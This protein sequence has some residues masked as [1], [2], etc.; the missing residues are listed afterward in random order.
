MLYL[1][2]TILATVILL[3]LAL[4]RLPYL[5][6][7]RLGMEIMSPRPYIGKSSSPFMDIWQRV[8]SIIGGLSSSVRRPVSLPMPSLTRPNT[9]QASVSPSGVATLPTSRETD[10]T[11]TLPMTAHPGDFWQEDAP[12][13]TGILEIPTKGLITR[14]GESQKIAHELVIRADESFRKKD[15]KEAEKF[16]L[17]AATKD[18]DNARIYSRLGVIYLQVKNYKDAVEAFRGALKFD[19]RVAS[20]HYNLALAYLGKK[21]YRL[22]ERGLREAVR[23]DPTNEKYR[24]T[25]GAIQ[26][27]VD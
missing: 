2:L 8:K 27:Q 23:L 18:P 12:Q 7:H 19:D 11:D 4:R 17:Q 6:T 1:I 21:D 3:A 20:R 22:A 16:Y 26:K 13:P 9:F 5:R 14:R 10:V 25:L 15:Y 24:Q